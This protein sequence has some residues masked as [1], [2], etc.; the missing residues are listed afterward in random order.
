M[1]DDS[2]DAER[3]YKLFL[4]E[5]ERIDK[6]NK[7]EGAKVGRDIGFKKALITW[8]VKHRRQLLEQTS[9]G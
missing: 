4:K 3:L 2:D 6:F 1:A 7:S 5:R 9:Q 8:I